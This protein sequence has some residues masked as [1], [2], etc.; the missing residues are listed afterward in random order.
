LHDEWLGAFASGKFHQR[1]G[2]TALTSTLPVSL[3]GAAADAPS[4]YLDPR[5]RRSSGGNIKRRSDLLEEQGRAGYTNDDDPEGPG[6]TIANIKSDPASALLL[7]SGGGGGSAGA[8]AAPPRD[9][10]RRREAVRGGGGGFSAGA[11]SLSSAKLPTRVEHQLLQQELQLQAHLEQRL[12]QIQQHILQMEGIVS[13]QGPIDYGT[14]LA[15][16]PSLC[17]KSGLAAGLAPPPCMFHPTAIPAIGMPPPASA[18]LI[19]FGS[20]NSESGASRSS[21]L[22]IEQRSDYGVQKFK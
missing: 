12:Q 13:G 1:Q 19:R 17:P 3:Y 2:R 10:K 11:S 16:W 18:G 9:N 4:R 20:T 5:C 14:G 6:A 8:A 7:L 21:D 22:S 15:P